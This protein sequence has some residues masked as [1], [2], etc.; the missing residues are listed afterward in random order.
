M[1]RILWILIL[2]LVFTGGTSAGAKKEKDN[3]TK[4]KT[5]ASTPAQAAPGSGQTTEPGQD[6]VIGPEDTLVINVWKEAELSTT[7]VVRPDGRIS[8]PLINEVQASGLTTK[9]LQDRIAER[10]KDFIASPV[11]TVMVKE[12]KSQSVT[13]MGEVTRTGVYPFGSP[14]TVVELIGRAGGFKDYAKTKGIRVLRN[15]NGQQLQF[16]F[17]YRDYIKGKNPEQNIVLKNGD[18]VI[19]P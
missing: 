6:F 14:M 11:V 17:N 12:I 15:E 8:L 1:K 10:L 5:D 4:G 3:K 9:Q 13:I 7:V 2:F 18:V 19:V 16:R